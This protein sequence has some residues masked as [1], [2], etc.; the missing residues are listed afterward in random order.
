MSCLFHVI[1]LKV[2]ASRDFMDGTTEA[3]ESTMNTFD[4]HRENACAEWQDK[5]KWWNQ[6]LFTISCDFF[7]HFQRLINVFRTIGCTEMISE[8]K[9]SISKILS[10]HVFHS[11]I[12]SWKK[13]TT[14]FKQ[15]LTLYQNILLDSCKIQRN[16][17]TSYFK[18][19]TSSDLM[20]NCW[21]NS[22]RCCASSKLAQAPRKFPSVELRQRN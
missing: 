20:T 3:H 16:K 21:A 10:L 11:F 12:I 6:I 14:F 9:Q 13:K 17:F 1:A 22:P 2:F 5:T 18:L 8:M 4:V 19:S 7:T 15:H